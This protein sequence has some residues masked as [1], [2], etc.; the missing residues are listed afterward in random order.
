[1]EPNTG[2]DETRGANGVIDGAN[3]GGS[4]C[5]EGSPDP[6]IGR[7]IKTK[8]QV[9]RRLAAGQTGTVYVARQ[10]RT[11]SRVAVKVFHAGITASEEFAKS[12]TQRMMAVRALSKTHPS[13]VS[14]YDFDRAE[15][16]SLFIAMELLEGRAL[17]EV[18]RQE[19]LLNVARAL[20]LAGEM[21]QALG[22]AHELGIVHADVRPQHFILS[23][24]MEAIKVIGFERARVREV[25]ATIPL[26]QAEVLPNLA[27]YLAPEQIRGEEITRQT[28]VYAFGVVLYE[29]LTGAVPCRPS[30]LGAAN[31]VHLEGVSTPLRTVRRELPPVIEAA[32]MQAL[33]SDPQRRQ[34]HLSDVVNDD[35]Y[36]AV[37]RELRPDPGPTPESLGSRLW[38][39]VQPDTG[40]TSEG[41]GETERAGVHWEL[42]VI[43]GLLVLLAISTWWT[44]RV[45]DASEVAPVPPISQSQD[46]ERVRGPVTAETP[47]GA[48]NAIPVPPIQAAAPPETPV[49]A[50][51]PSRKEN[52]RTRIGTRAPTQAKANSPRRAHPPTPSPSETSG[53][54]ADSP[55]PTEV[56]DWLLR[57]HSA[58]R[59]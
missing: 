32:V 31:A 15:D 5:G 45:Q 11:G 42:A 21:A 51:T 50:S 54:P 58:G 49:G 44:L 28:D 1:M 30:T 56:I 26:I 46:R 40:E 43:G 33:E 27:A 35:L 41:L 52:Q 39:A 2:S 9:I 29:M 6:W 24:E 8:Y 17:S 12:F 25:G 14:V 57:G 36:D 22:V 37:L 20:R 59:P 13:I 16:G 55:D 47:G 53:T 7:L 19:G 10:L 23:R 34:R 18:I 4:G 3:G 38:L 48:I